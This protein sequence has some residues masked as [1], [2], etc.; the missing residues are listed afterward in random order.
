[1]TTYF[2]RNLINKAKAI[3]G[4]LPDY[5]V[6]F[7]PRDL[8]KEAKE[9]IEIF[10]SGDYS[11][12]H[13]QHV[14]DEVTKKIGN[15]SVD[16]IEELLRYSGLVGV[17][18]KYSDADPE[19]LRKKKERRTKMAHEAKE[20]AKYSGLGTSINEDVDLFLS[21]LVELANEIKSKCKVA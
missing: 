18:N 4:N 21:R 2:L 7:Q 13:E 3:D 8:E 15:V 14:L 16:K 9:L 19:E 5:L 20:I 6:P 11:M 1:M 17:M 12:A 10:R